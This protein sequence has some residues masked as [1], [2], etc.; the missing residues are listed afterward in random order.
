MPRFAILWRFGAFIHP[1]VADHMGHA[2]A[3]VVENHPPPHLLHVAVFFNVAPVLDGLFVF[4]K[5]KRKKLALL[6]HTFKALHRNETRHGFQK[7]LQIQR[8]GE[9]S[10]RLAV[11]RLNFKDDGDHGFHS[12]RSF[13]NRHPSEGWGPASIHVFWIQSGI[14]AFAGM[15]VVGMAQEVEHA[16]K[17]SM[18]TLI[19]IPAL[20]CDAGLYAPFNAAL[21]VQGKTIVAVANRMAGC[22]EQVLASAPRDFILMGT[23]FGGR[24]AMETAL[25]APARVKG[26]ILIGAGPGPVVDQAAGLKRSARV[27]G[28]EFE[29]VL[30][31][32]GDIISHLPGPRGPQ[33]MEAFRAMSRK[34]GPENFALQSDALA[35]RT[36]LWP[37]MGEI[38]CPVLCLWGDHDQYTSAE[39]GQKISVAVPHGQCVI[40][41]ACGHFPILEYPAEAARVVREWLRNVS[42]PLAGRD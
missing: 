10:I 32:M 29:E 23:S 21:G 16:M 26:L 9:I 28:A 14:P 37:R 42:L 22:V 12:T 6:R 31:E 3:V 40:L 7:R 20:G 5:R 41:P 15:T 33:T 19:Q 13:P 8:L 36:D 35:Y 1:I 11:M 39:V 4:P 2:Q 38:K 30:Q 18:L 27:R 24:V 34:L 17:L 25:A